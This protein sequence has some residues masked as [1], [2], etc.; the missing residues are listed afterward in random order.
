MLPQITRQNVTEPTQ[1]ALTAALSAAIA[2]KMPTVIHLGEAAAEKLLPD[3]TPEFLKKHVHELTGVYES[4]GAYP[5][6]GPYHDVNRPLARALRLQPLHNYT[7]VAKP[8]STTA[9]FT[10]AQAQQPKHRYYSGE[11]YRLPPAMQDTLQPLER[12]L[13]AHGPSHASVN[14]WLGRWPVV[15]P[16]HYDG[17]HNAVAQLSGKKQF[18]LAPPS[19][20]RQVRAYPFLHPSHAQCQVG[21]D[22]TDDAELAAQG[23][24]RIT[25]SRGD[26]LYLPP[27]WFH[28]ATA[29]D[30]DGAVGIN[31]WVD[32]EEGQAAAELFEMPRPAKR[33]AKRGHGSSSAGVAATAATMMTS[34]DAGGGVVNGP[35]DAE[36]PFASAASLVLLL[37]EATLGL[38]ALLVRRV[39]EERYAALIT[40]GSLPGARGAG[41]AALVECGMIRSWRAHWAMRE[42]AQEWASAA[43]RL[44]GARFSDASRGLWLANLAEYVAAER[45]GLQAVGGFWRELHGCLV[46]DAQKLPE[47]E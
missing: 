13:I 7:E 18:V 8:M 5:R 15:A 27:L 47:P 25:L 44:A 19:A 9:F 2:A 33:G 11:T 23:G 42:D 40:S 22:Q 41:G 35:D 31:G 4:L 36:T 39:W 34:V 28:E 21:L 16:C 10:P 20:W 46:E 14:L 24:R 45:V 6:F 37:S 3:W 17:Y 29:L 43:A 12:S 30:L 38:P 1:L 32:S 26:V